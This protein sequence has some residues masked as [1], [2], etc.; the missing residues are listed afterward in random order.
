MPP[1]HVFCSPE[2]YVQ[3]AGATAVL[4]AQLAHL[5][6]RGPVLIVAGRSQCIPRDAWAATLVRTRRPGCHPTASVGLALGLRERQ[7][8]AGVSSGHLVVWG[9]DCAD[10][11]KACPPA[12]STFYT[13]DSFAGARRL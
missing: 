9:M 2:R 10:C 12:H 7:P 13:P 1:V 8:G 4:G 3:G 6:L 11:E 5:K